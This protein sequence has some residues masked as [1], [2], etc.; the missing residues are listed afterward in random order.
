M[1]VARDTWDRLRPGGGR[2]CCRPMKEFSG[3][4]SRELPS[5]IADRCCIC[6]QRRLFPCLMAPYVVGTKVSML[7]HARRVP[8][9][10]ACRPLLHSKSVCVITFDPLVV[11]ASPCSLS[12]F[13]ACKQGQPLTQLPMLPL[14]QGLRSLLDPQCWCRGLIACRT[15]TCILVEVS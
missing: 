5:P 10:S 7:V 9:G 2:G 4:F 8:A 11:G 14:P 6:G 12:F 13:D 1:L 3:V 15:T